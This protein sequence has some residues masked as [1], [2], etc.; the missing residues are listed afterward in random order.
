MLSIPTVSTSQACDSATGV[1]VA[2][3][4]PI[5]PQKTSDT[6]DIF[7]T[8]QAP[9]S[10]G[11]V[12]FGFG[13]NMIGSLSFV[14]WR[15]KNDVVT[16]CRYA[17][18][19]RPHNFRPKID[20]VFFSSHLQ[21]EVYPGPSVLVLSSNITSTAFIATLQ[22]KNVTRWKDN[23]KLDI[24]SSAAGIVWALGASPPDNPSNPSSNFQQHKAMGVFWVDMKSAQ[25]DSGL[26]AAP[27]ITGDKILN[28]A[29]IGLT[30][31]DKVPH[32]VVK[33]KGVDDS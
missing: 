8:F 29:G 27:S 28:K 31:R 24:E 7:A 12:G 21:P 26:P 5:T 14:M 16:S 33:E 1:C 18:Y 19:C 15:D 13:E 32:R 2:F 3:S 20:D 9:G 10:L 4:I 23:G 25:A 17:L 6:A 30:H 22:L 11:W